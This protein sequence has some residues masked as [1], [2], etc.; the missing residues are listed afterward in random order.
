M[1]SKNFINI[2]NKDIYAKLLAIDDKL[3]SLTSKVNI[4]GYAAGI[5]L[6][7]S[8]TSLGFIFEFLINK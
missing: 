8:L 2:T 5:A 1:T 7:L 4:S 6:T 3:E